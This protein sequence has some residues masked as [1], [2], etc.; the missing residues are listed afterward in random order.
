[1]HPALAAAVPTC[2]PWRDPGNPLAWRD[3]FPPLKVGKRLLIAPTWR[4]VDPG[5]RHLLEIDPGLA[6]GTGHHSTTRGC[7]LEIERLSEAANPKSI[8]DVGCG[9]GV[10]ALAGHLLGARRIAAVDTDSLAREATLEAFERHGVR[11][12]LVGSDV[13]RLRKTFDLVVANLFVDSLVELAPILAARTHP[14]GHLVVSGLL[15]RQARQVRSAME[16]QGLVLERRRRLRCWV[17]LTF[18][19]PQAKRATRSKGGSSRA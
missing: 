9:S 2:E 19:R 3:H 10:L 12:F 7:L 4:N 6:F 1:M 15:D 13:K 5:K 8:L 17:V 14:G 16:A 18:V 11:G